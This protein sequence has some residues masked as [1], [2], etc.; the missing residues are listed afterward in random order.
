MIRFILA[1]TLLAVTPLRAQ[2][3]NDGATNT[4]SNVTNSITGDVIVGTNGTFTLLVLSDNALLTNS[5]NGVISLNATA[6]AN[7][8][9]LVSASARWMMNGTLYVGS[10]GAAARLVVSNGAF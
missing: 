9:R 5:A 7:E 10:N 1:V 4:L 8:A 2:I 3:V 6:S